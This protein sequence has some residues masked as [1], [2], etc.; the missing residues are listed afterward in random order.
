MSN[1]ERS[2][3][4]EDVQRVDIDHIYR[5]LAD[6]GLRYGPAFR[7]LRAVWSHGDEVYA[8]AELDGQRGGD[9]EYHLHPALF[10]AALQSALV[11]GL[12]SESSTFLPFALRGVRLHR[13]GAR[14]VNVHTVPGDDG[15]VSLAL[16]GQDGDPVATVASLVRRPVTADQLDAAVRRTQLLRVRWKPVEQPAAGADQ[17]RWAFLGTDHIGLTGALKAM[18]RPFDSF[19]SLRALDAALRAK[20]PVPDVFVVSCTDQDSAAQAVA[21]RAL[22]LVQEWLADDRLATARLVLVSSGAVATR[23]DDPLSDVS[24]AAVWGLLRSAQAEHPGRFVLVDIDDPEDA[25]RSLAAAVASGEPQLAV[26]RGALLRPRLARS[27]PPAKRP[28]LTGTVLLTGGTGAL[29]RLVARHLVTAHDVEHLV[30]LSRRGPQAPGATEL[31]AEL[32]AS[33]ARVSLVACDVADRTAL[34]RAL[35]DLPAPSAV[36]HAAGTLADAAVETLTPGRLDKVLRPKVDA[37]LH[38]HELISDPACAFVVFSSVAGLIGNQGQANYAAANAVLDAL[39]HHRRTLGLH[40]VSLAWGLW[41]GDD[42]MGAALSASDLARIGRSGLAPLAPEQGLALLDAAF[43]TD[44]ALLAPVRLNEARLTGEVPPVLAE[45]APA[46]P[47]PPTATDTLRGRL[48]ELPE[49][50]HEAAVLEFVRTAVAA[51]LGFDGP[52]DVV[53]DRE[54]GSVGLDS[55]GNLELSRR[56]SAGVGSRLPATLAF[57]HPTPAGLAAH[58]RRL[59]R[60]SAR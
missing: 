50:E 10:D 13:A 7:G 22:M 58:L 4:P 60:E 1:T 38:L 57:D 55:I 2:G 8:E 28:A 40:G 43:A 45:L 32:T 42:G 52:E 21:Q 34:E 9:G 24:G 17:R 46:R 37:A 26:R 35:A 25:E 3:Q 5:R 44:E 51:V 53:P 27:Q 36:I 41:E 6:R 59:V 47:G 19:P 12:D 30:L 49:A 14:A 20:A 39:A 11:P 56:L 23:A 33:G 15:V 16:T 29:G 18:P 48:A 54:F 31:S